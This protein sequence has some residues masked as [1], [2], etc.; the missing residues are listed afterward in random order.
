MY[1]KSNLKILW[2]MSYFKYKIFDKE[3]IY[4]HWIELNSLFDLYLMNN[5]N[6]T[7]SA[8]LISWTF[9]NY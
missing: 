4:V 1:L 5:A 2:Q 6:L 8:E 7:Y 3:Y 9:N